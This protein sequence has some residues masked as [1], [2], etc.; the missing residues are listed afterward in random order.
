M[1]GAQP[2]GLVPGDSHSEELTDLAARISTQPAEVVFWTGP[3]AQAVY[4]GGGLSLDVHR[5]YATQITISLGDPVV[6]QTAAHRRSQQSFVVGPNVA[7]GIDSAATPIVEI[8]SE[9]RA[10]SDFA[11]RVRLES[12]ADA[13]P[14]P[15]DL[16]GDL[17]PHLRT[18]GERGLDDENGDAL[19]T[20]LAKRL[21]IT[22]LDETGDPRIAAAR[23]FVTP[24]FLLGEDRPIDALASHVHL[25]T[26]RFRHV[27]RDEV[28][29]SIQSYLRWQRLLVAMAATA[30]GTSLT[31]AAHAAGFADSAHLTRVFRATFG[32]APSR[33]FKDSHFVQVITAGTQ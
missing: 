26:S 10:M 6:V 5:H 2:M 30:K 28:G 33:I 31:E 14:L 15:T 27:W 7:H 20:G 4:V 19:L 12:N 16:L 32:I 29:M 17:W 1:R 9:A 25:S 21:L 11:S 3:P 18:I 23:S 13:P 8:F 22:S 24:E